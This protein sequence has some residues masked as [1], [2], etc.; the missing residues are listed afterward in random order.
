MKKNI[1]TAKDWLILGM[2]TSVAGTV[3]KAGINYSM[4]RRH[5]FSL[6]KM[7]YIDDSARVKQKQAAVKLAASLAVGGLQGL[8]FRRYALSM[9]GQGQPEEAVKNKSDKKR[10]AILKG[11]RKKQLED[12]PQYDPPYIQ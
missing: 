7:L 8:L 10:A 11:G 1:P 4:D 3:V 5:L 9:M 6:R 2:I 12:I